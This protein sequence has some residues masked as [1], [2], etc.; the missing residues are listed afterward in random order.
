MSASPEK[1]WFQLSI[2]CSATQAEQIADILQGL[3]ALSI[4][5]ADGKDQPLYQLE[6][7]DHPLW[8]DT[9]VTGLF[10]S[11]QE[12]TQCQLLLNSF[13]EQPLP[14]KVGSIAEQ[15]WVRLTQQ[16]FPAQSFGDNEP[17]LWVVPSWQDS[18][19]YQHKII[20]DPGLAFGT[21][22]HPTT[23]LCLQWLANNPPKDLQV[24]DYGC[25]SGILSLAAL[26]LDANRV[27]AVDHDP[28]ALES[29]NNNLA[30]N[31]SIKPCSLLA[32][33]PE[34]CPNTA[35]DLVIANI[36]ANPLIT[37]SDQLTRLTQA[38]GRLLI[39]GIL[40]EEIEEVTKH[41]QEFSV[42]EK[43]ILDGWACVL[44]NKDSPVT[45]I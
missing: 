12:A 11:Q 4:T 2:A 28:Q 9:V 19:D 8:Q 5:L 17:F 3:D 35:A 16:N 7:E 15:D 27:M 34:Q 1:T 44:L 14:C 43:S 6:P 37:L 42:A 38:N 22:T 10:N 25:G 40:Q 32:F 26:A 21:G 33:S 45:K 30:L 23:H 41:Y 36:L 24:I 29:T 18:S 31:D 20:I 13:F 39:S